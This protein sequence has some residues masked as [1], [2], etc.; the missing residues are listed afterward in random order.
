M[1]NLLFILCFCVSTQI[2][3]AHYSTGPTLKI[4]PESE[5]ISQNP[6]FLLIYPNI[7]K[8]AKEVYNQ[9]YL[10]DENGNIINLEIIGES[11]DTRHIEVEEYYGF[12]S[13]GSVADNGLSDD[14]VLLKAKK[15]LPLNAKVSLFIE[16]GK[17]EIVKQNL[18][19]RSWEVKYKIDKTPPTF[20]SEIMAIYRPSLNAACAGA[21]H[22]VS[23]IL[24]TEDNIPYLK[25]YPEYYS[26]EDKLKYGKKSE[27]M[28][29]LK[30]SSGKKYVFLIE[31]GKAYWI[32]NTDSNL[33]LP[34]RIEEN[35]DW[36]LEARLIDFS[37]NR[38]L[39]SKSLRLKILK[40]QSMIL[41]YTYL[42]DGVEETHSRR[43]ISQYDSYADRNPRVLCIDGTHWV[44]IG[45]RNH[46]SYFEMYIEKKIVDAFPIEKEELI[47][48]KI[49]AF[50]KNGLP[51][52]DVCQLDVN[53]DEMFIDNIIWIDTGSKDRQGCS[54][55]QN[56]E[57][58]D[59]STKKYS[60]GAFEKWIKQ[61]TPNPSFTETVI[62]YHLP[63]K[64]DSA[65]LKIRDSLGTEVEIVLTH[66]GRQRLKLDTSIIPPGVYFYILIVNGEVIDTKK[67]LVE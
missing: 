51:K 53:P 43:H 6:V 3:F 16:M 22:N 63:H 55:Y 61:N 8:T 24:Q 62:E 17:E 47:G 66:T 25:N 9:I 4:Y 67:M 27:M 11:E 20:K 30:D 58:Y 48:E 46:D 29:E 33:N 42:L 35:M 56:K 37:G 32:G 31:N 41:E 2:A 54:I 50:Q 64:I 21:N 15:I 36:I 59:I 5:T 13:D 49:T 39:E 65:V 44:N 45:H 38:S 26:E 40:H 28:I 7:Q 18:N 23:I 12:R 34:L 10:E 1:K 52:K 14:Y 57:V 19:K 60:C